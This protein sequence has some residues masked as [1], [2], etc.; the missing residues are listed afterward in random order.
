MCL[1]QA[2]LICP[3]LAHLTAVGV[4]VLQVRAELGTAES[5]M[6]SPD[7]EL[8]AHVD[9][10]TT[11]HPAANMLLV[12]SAASGQQLTVVPLAP[13]VLYSCTFWTP[14]SQLLISINGL[15]ATFVDRQS[16]ATRL[17]QI[18]LS[19]QPDY[20]YDGLHRAMCSRAGLVVVAQL[21]EQRGII[22][23]CSLIGKPQELEV[24]RQITTG[25]VVLGFALSPC[26]LLLAWA[27]F[28]GS[29]RQH[30]DPEALFVKVRAKPCVQVC[31]LATGRCATLC[32]G[33]RKAEFSWTALPASE[34]AFAFEAGLLRAHACLS[35]TSSGT[36]VCMWAPKV[37]PAT[38]KTARLRSAHQ[39]CLLP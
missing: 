5:A 6:W 32:K 18:S 11:A 36:T 21:G 30:Q 16:H 22:S 17:Q 23:I 12:T 15:Q 3:R 34:K 39:V 9:Q 1:L 29:S 28:G 26:G 35:W 2:R 27:D 4:E 20:A 24:L 19:Q 13:P 25:T 10:S 33:A 7:G 31:E 14:D 37:N 38:G 8:V